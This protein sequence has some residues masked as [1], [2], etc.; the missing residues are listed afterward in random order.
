M[1]FDLKGAVRGVRESKPPHAN[2]SKV[3]S[4]KMLQ[5][6][7]GVHRYQVSGSVPKP[8][9]E[10]FTQ[11]LFEREEAAAGVIGPAK[12]RGLFG[13]LFKEGT[14]DRSFKYST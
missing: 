1:D 2:Q 14:S 11:G 5:A 9:L 12:P 13:W 4:L 10:N 6:D 8:P 7:V 3:Q